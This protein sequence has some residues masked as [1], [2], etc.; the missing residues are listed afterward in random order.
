MLAL[1]HEPPPPLPG[2]KPI[3][4]SEPATDEQ[5][6][7]ARW[8]P[9][10]LMGVG[11]GIVVAGGIMILVDED[12]DKTGKQDP[13]IRNT[14]TGGLLL[15]ISGGVAIGAGYYLWRKQKSSAPVA[16]VSSDGGYVGWA[17]R[18]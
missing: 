14:A 16:A 1:V 12:L 13:T 5:S 4:V 15:A 11:A 6:S 8:A 2:A 17:G 18:F 3:A 7:I 9:L 10:G